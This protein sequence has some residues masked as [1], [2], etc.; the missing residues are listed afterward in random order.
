V[1]MMSPAVIMCGHPAG[2]IMKLPFVMGVFRWTTEPFEDQTHKKRFGLYVAESTWPPN[3][4]H[5]SLRPPVMGS[6]SAAGPGPIA[7]TVLLPGATCVRP[8]SCTT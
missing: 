3:D 6:K 7:S 8:A 1:S 4:P 5:R 2:I